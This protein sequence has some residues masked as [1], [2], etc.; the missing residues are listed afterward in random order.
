[1]VAAFVAACRAKNLSAQTIEF[2]LKALHAYRAFSGAAT[3][4]T[5]GRR[6]A[7]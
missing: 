2:Y 5:Y 3:R 7:V 1:V 6:A 4:E